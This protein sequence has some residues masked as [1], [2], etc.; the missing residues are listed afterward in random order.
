MSALPNYLIRQIFGLSRTCHM[1]RILICL[2]IYN[3]EDQYISK[4]LSFL[5]SIKNNS[6]SSKIFIYLCNNNNI[7]KRYSKSFVQAIKL[8]ES[9][10][11]MENSVI[12]EKPLVFTKLLKMRSTVAPRLVSKRYGLFLSS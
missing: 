11:H 10:F 8:L 9:N 5:E 3:M 2:H 12:F 6:V 4:N 1:S 7:S